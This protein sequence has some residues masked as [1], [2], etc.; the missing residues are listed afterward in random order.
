MLKNCIGGA[1]FFIPLSLKL[2]FLNVGTKNK[3]FV[4][5]LLLT[6]LE[7]NHNLDAG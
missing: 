7:V 1:L 5:P 6:T 2:R 3:K 4:K